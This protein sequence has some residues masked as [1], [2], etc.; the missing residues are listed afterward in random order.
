M[1]KRND[2]L[3]SGILLIVL[4]VIVITQIPSIRITKMASDARL[5]PKI[6]SVILLVLGAVL[7]Y[8]G[9]TDLMKRRANNETPKESF[10]ADGAFRVAACLVLFGGFIFL[11]PRI[12]F[13][14]AG[15]L[16]LVLS[17]YLLAPAGKKNHLLIWITGIL[18]PVVIYFLFVKGFKLLLPTGNI[19]R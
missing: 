9:I 5:M 4:A 16:Y 12:G 2:S 6:V 7:L 10:H 1:I 15:I 13:I 8:Q 3:F 18:V 17:F 11:M 14:L 19:F